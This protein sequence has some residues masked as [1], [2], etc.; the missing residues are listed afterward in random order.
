[1]ATSAMPSRA[2]AAESTARVSKRLM[3]LPATGNMNIIAKLRIEK[4]MVNDARATPK[5][6]LT[7]VKK[8]PAQLS[9]SAHGMPAITMPAATIRYA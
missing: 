3:S 5:Y 7:G 2:T 6:S 8:M 1:M 4:Y 9:T